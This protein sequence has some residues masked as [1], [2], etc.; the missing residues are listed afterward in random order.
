MRTEQAIA[1]AKQAAQESAMKAAYYRRGFTQQAR[2]ET[3]AAALLIPSELILFLPA[4]IAGFFL[5][6]CGVVAAHAAECRRAPQ[7]VPGVVASGD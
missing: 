3:I 6:M 5:F 7:K 4:P 1:Q 2:R